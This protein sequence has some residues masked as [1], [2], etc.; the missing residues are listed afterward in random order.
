M[1]RK[2]FIE[3]AAVIALLAN[4]VIYP[5]TMVITH[6]DYF[7]DTVIVENATGFQYHFEGVEDLIPGDV[8]S[9]VMYSNGTP[10][11]I[12]DDEVVSAR[13]S[14]FIAEDFHNVYTEGM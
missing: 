3:L 7:T 2:F 5:S 6:V 12:A 4:G 9:V 10:W 11:T 1:V 13:Y 14:G 8:V